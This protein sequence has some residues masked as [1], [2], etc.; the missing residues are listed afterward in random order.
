MNRTSLSFIVVLLIVIAGGGSVSASAESNHTDPCT[1]FFDSVNDS[2]QSMA[3]GVVPQNVVKLWKQDLLFTVCIKS[4]Q[5]NDETVTPIFSVESSLPDAGPPPDRVFQYPLPFDVTGKFVYV[6]ELE[7]GDTTHFNITG[8]GASP[9]GEHR[10]TVT[11]FRERIPPK[12]IGVSAATVKISCPMGCQL[13]RGTMAIIEY[14]LDHPSFSLA[15]LGGLLGFLKRQQIIA[16]F[17]SS[18]G[19][20]QKDQ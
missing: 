15:A 18:D 9:P 4:P 12:P 5:R 7:P 1:D 16:F 20:S 11:G 10:V 19:Q 3:F 17:T 8:A 13:A 14:G 2:Q 6:G